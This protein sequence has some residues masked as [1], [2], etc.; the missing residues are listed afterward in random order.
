MMRVT[1]FRHRM[2]EGVGR[3]VGWSALLGAA[4][5]SLAAFPEARH[6]RPRAHFANLSQLGFQLVPSEDQSVEICS[7]GHVFT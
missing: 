1:V 7:S 4:A 6:E 5:G 2:R 3:A